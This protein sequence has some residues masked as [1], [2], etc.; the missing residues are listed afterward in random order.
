M[1]KIAAI[2]NGI[3]PVPKYFR[4]DQPISSAA[5]MCSMMNVKKT[6]LGL[7]SPM[8]STVLRN[9]RKSSMIGNCG[10]EMTVSETQYRK[11]C[12]LVESTGYSSMHL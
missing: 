11:Y 6:L 8:S 3:Q 1:R 10:T 7:N 9:L 2:I 5:K 12:E 4:I